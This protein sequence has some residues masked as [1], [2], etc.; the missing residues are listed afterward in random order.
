MYQRI[1]QSLFLFQA[2]FTPLGHLLLEYIGCIMDLDGLDFH[3]LCYL[4]KAEDSER[5][6]ILDK[7]AQNRR[8]DVCF[9]LQKLFA[10][11]SPSPC[12]QLLLVKQRRL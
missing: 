1:L 4:T 12:K 11:G 3:L 10:E 7:M 2:S 9:L 5:S 6:Y 8:K